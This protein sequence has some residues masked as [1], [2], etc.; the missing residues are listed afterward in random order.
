MRT[1]HIVNQDA[2]VNGQSPSGLPPLPKHTVSPDFLFPRP[3]VQGFLGLI[4]HSILS[5][6][7]RWKC[8][9]SARMNSSKEHYSVLK[10]KWAWKS[11]ALWSASFSISAPPTQYVW[12]FSPLWFRVLVE[13]MFCCHLCILERYVFR[14]AFLPHSDSDTSSICSTSGQFIVPHSMCMAWKASA[15]SLS[16]NKT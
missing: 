10:N 11:E 1:D 8:F 14:Q 15:F 13:H 12:M 7:P 9:P 6:R 16:I 5:V 3:S 2:D 4:F